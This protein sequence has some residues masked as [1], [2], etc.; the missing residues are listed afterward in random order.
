MIPSLVSRN[1]TSNEWCWNVNRLHEFR[2]IRGRNYI[3]HEYNGRSSFHRFHT[4]PR[5]WSHH[6]P[7]SIQ[8]L[9]VPMLT[10]LV[11]QRESIIGF[12][13]DQHPIHFVTDF[14]LVLSPQEAASSYKISFVHVA[15]PIILDH[16]LFLTYSH[17]RGYFFTFHSARKNKS[18]PPLSS[19]LSI[20]N[21]N[22]FIWLE[23]RIWQQLANKICR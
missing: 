21:K 11:S 15:L 18:W 13:C 8:I 10:F 17:H 4:C 6:L 23:F 12:F 19:V 20:I 14:S 5:H 22:T 3:F 2:N 1:K 16:T 9:S 7:H